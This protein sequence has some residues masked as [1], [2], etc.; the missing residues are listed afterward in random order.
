LAN[1]H[2]ATF[3]FVIRC[4][5][6]VFRFNGLLSSFEPV[7]NMSQSCLRVNVFVYMLFNGTRTGCLGQ[8]T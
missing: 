6:F 7:Y 2:Q 4:S 3:A 1:W 5:R 8:N